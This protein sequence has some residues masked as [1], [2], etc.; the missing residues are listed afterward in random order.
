MLRLT[1]VAM[2]AVGLGVGA[3]TASASWKAQYGVQD[4]AWLEVG[5]TKM[6]SLQERLSMLHAAVGSRGAVQ[7]GRACEP[8][9]PGL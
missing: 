4:D 6:S 1:L 8:R 3:S 9:R 2:L 5:T 7:A